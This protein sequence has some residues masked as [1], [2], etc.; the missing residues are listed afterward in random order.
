[1]RK[2]TEEEY[3]KT[4]AS[5]EAEALWKHMSITRQ[6]FGCYLSC[7]GHHSCP[8]EPHDGHVTWHYVPIACN[9]RLFR[10]LYLIL[11]LFKVKCLAYTPN[12][13]YYTKHKV[14]ECPWRRYLGR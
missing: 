13:A 5:W 12:G 10:L 3:M 9:G 7:D 11:R 8:S 1:M 14:G 6:S 2:L 4:L